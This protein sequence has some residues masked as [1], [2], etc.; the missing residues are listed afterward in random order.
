MIIS[1]RVRAQLEAIVVPLIAV[2]VAMVVFGLFI[3][4]N[5]K[6]PIELYGLMVKGAFGSWFSWQN[7]LTRSAPLMLAALC[8]ALPARVGLI[9]IGGE[10]ALV[11]GGL[12]AAVAGLACTTLPAWTAL[13]AMVISG[14][15]AGGLWI[16]FA[17]ALRQFRGV[18]ETISSL[19]LGYVAIAMLN[20][21]VE[22]VL[23][24]PE[25]RNKPST[26]HIGEEHMLGT[27][28]GSDIHWGLGLGVIACVVAWLVTNRSVFGF[29]AAMVGGNLRAA[30]L[31]GLPVGRIVVIMCAL[32][33]AAAGIAGA[34]EVA[35]VHGRANASLASG[36]G[37]TGI[38]VAFLARHNPLAVIPVAILIGGIIA[39]GG[40]LQRRMQLPDATVL[41]FQGTLFI[42]ILASEALYGRFRWFSAPPA[43]PPAPPVPVTSAAAASHG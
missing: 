3:L 29:S 19:L 27:M 14:A 33:G 37:Y 22:G 17:G 6:N 16:A 1:A 4:L 36:Y 9:I 40:L 39:S 30:K 20:H 31:T 2:F 28:F 21:L 10:G 5:G 25:S 32:A 13:A 34:V 7:T 15:I 24:D 35:A 43:D 12:A 26:S 23:R 41:V 11:L 18:N 38:L 42:S 8:T